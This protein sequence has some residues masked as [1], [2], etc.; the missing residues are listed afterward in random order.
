MESAEHGDR[1]TNSA[2]LFGQIPFPI[3]EHLRLIGDFD[4]GEDEKGYFLDILDIRPDVDETADAWYRLLIFPGIGDAKLKKIREKAVEA[5]ITD[6]VSF[7]NWSGRDDL[8][9]KSIPAN[10]REGVDP[11]RYMEEIRHELPRIVSVYEA[12]R[13]LIAR[14]AAVPVPKLEELREQYITECERY[15]QSF[16]DWIAENPFRLCRIGF[17]A[18]RAEDLT[19]SENLPITTADPERSRAYLRVAL[20]QI[21]GDGHTAFAISTLQAALQRAIRRSTIAPPEGEHIGAPA[22]IGAVS[23][24]RH[25]G[26]GG[27][28]FGRWI[29]EDGVEICMQSKRD[30][31]IARGI[32]SRLRGM[33][34]DRRAYDV[35]QMAVMLAEDRDIVLTDEQREAADGVMDSGVHIITGGPGTGKT[36][37]VKAIIARLETAGI[38]YKLT[39]PTG[40]AAE[41]LAAATDREATTIHS[42]IGKE[43]GEAVCKHN[44]EDP[45]AAEYYIVD[46]ASMLDEE[47]LCD[48]L[49]ATPETAGLL[50]VGDADQLPSV[51]PGNVLRD[52]LSCDWIP[53][54]RLGRVFRQDDD[55]LAE[56]IARIR[57]GRTDLIHGDDT[58]VHI[59]SHEYAGDVMADAVRIASDCRQAGQTMVLSPVRNKRFEV[60]VPGL[61]IQIQAQTNP[62]RGD[63]VEHHGYR[64]HA[65]DPVVFLI[66]KKTSDGNYYNGDVGIIQ[67]VNAGAKMVRVLMRD[68]VYRL[69]GPAI[70]D[71][72]LA[73]ATTIHKSQ[74]SEADTVVV[75][76]PT[77]LGHMMTREL[78]YVAVT[79]AKR[80]VYII[81]QTPD[82]HLEDQRTPV[83]VSI[84]TPGKTRYTVLRDLL[85]GRQMHFERILSQIDPIPLPLTVS[86]VAA[87]QVQEML[88]KL[89]WVLARTPRDKTTERLVAAILRQKLY[90]IEDDVREQIAAWSWYMSTLTGAEIGRTSEEI[91]IYQGVLGIVTTTKQDTLALV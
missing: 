15:S 52:L 89:S 69:Q 86:K 57:A 83:E 87:N 8:I 24:L 3:P 88:K 50:L 37:M 46:E 25:S 56:D 54:Y 84:E 65:G 66:N 5:G 11:S 34:L 82:W 27:E 76:L 77:D 59:I 71:I 51:G 62:V 74:G 47:L 53:A 16:K 41:R 44:A 2:R 29:D 32:A 26:A 85:A 63:F 35:D 55:I 80:Q 6:F 7:L 91:K 28:L 70:G 19:I 33:N 13:W 10:R 12:S 17:S 4:R 23:A 48:L 78:L 39:A 61:N 9:L 67:D 49:G 72:D 36:T 90:T 30:A 75:V 21:H 14:R 20:G 58:P 1:I 43:P 73:Y 38:S 68:K 64:F 60:S 79:R 22:G 42:L 81:Q 18:R 45:I 31:D 40:K